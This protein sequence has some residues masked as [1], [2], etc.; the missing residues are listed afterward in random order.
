MNRKRQAYV[1]PL[2]VR[3]SRN[4]YSVDLLLVIGG[5]I[6]LVLSIAYIVVA[7]Y[8]SA[9]L[10]EIQHKDFSEANMRLRKYEAFF[11]NLRKQGFDVDE[12]TPYIKEGVKNFLWAVTVPGT[13]R[14]LI[15]R[16]RHDLESNKVEPLTSS[17]TYLDIQLRYISPK[18]AKNY[19]YDPGDEIARRV[20]AGTFDVKLTLSQS[21]PEEEKPAD[22]TEEVTE[23]PMGE[24]GGADEHKEEVE[25]GKKTKEGPQSGVSKG[26]SVTVGAG[27][28]AKDTEV[29]DEKKEEVD[30]RAESDKGDEAEK[31]DES[32]TEEDDAEE[33]GEDSSDSESNA[34]N[35]H[36]RKP[37]GEEGR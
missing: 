9:V 8:I 27:D 14:R 5:T 25:D 26:E 2:R 7:L 18:D 22:A 33:G 32:A 29:G 34:E 36:Q 6:L 13:G 37:S 12:S 17:A 23:E 31:S 15:Y 24:E 35:D 4:R 10:A 19:P 1:R 30:E 16:W 28:R 3:F 21:Q 20:A 11:E